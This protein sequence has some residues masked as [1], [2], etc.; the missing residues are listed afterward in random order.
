MKGFS[1]KALLLNGAAVLIIVAS[2]GAVLRGALFNEDASPCLDR[3]AKGAVLTLSRD[4]QPLVTEDLQSRA[5]GTDWGLLDGARIVKLKTGPAPFALEM[6]LG[7]VKPRPGATEARPGLGFTWSP[8][9]FEKASAACLAY[10]VFLPEDFEFG[11]G[12][13]LPGLVGEIKNETAE[14][15]ETAFSTRYAWRSDG[16]GDIHTHL[17]GWPVGRSLGNDRGGFNFT[18]G[19]WVSLEQ[20]VVLN[21]ADAKNGLIRIW[22]D[23][24]LRY[25]KSSL[26]MRER[27][28]GTGATA[29]P[30]L[31]GVLSEVSM[32][33]DAPGAKQKLWLTA[34]ELRWR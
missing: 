7:A 10:S 20:E 6:N 14:V 15:K 17:P 8:R 25:E 30:A 24:N 19:R 31:A 16:S 28:T 29:F 1:N 5:G 21:D 3:Y 2:A 26:V 9:G 4:G 11:R 22:V 33:G 27:A 12:G 18:K 23:G 34:F 32:P 13:I